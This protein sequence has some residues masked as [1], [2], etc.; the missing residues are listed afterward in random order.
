MKEHEQ[1]YRNQCERSVSI[2]NM[3]V[4]RRSG[5]IKIGGKY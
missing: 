3:C 1:T 2:R 5:L 4:R